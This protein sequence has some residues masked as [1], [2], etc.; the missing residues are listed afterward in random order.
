MARNSMRV[1]PGF[2]Q[3]FWSWLTAKPLVEELDNKKSLKP[4]HHILFSSS[5]IAI[6]TVLAGVGYLC[7]NFLLWLLGFA[8]A[9]GGIKQMQ[10][11]ICHNCAHD[12]VFESAW[13]NELAGT[14][15]SG[16]FILKPFEIY[17]KEHVLHHSSKALLTHRDDTLSFLQS[18]VGL[19][20]SDS[21]EAMWIKLVTRALSPVVIL[22]SAWGRLSSTA[23]APNKKVAA[24]TLAFWAATSLIAAV[25]GWI[26]VFMVAYVVPVFAGYHISSTFRLA[27]EHTWPSIDVLKR[28]GVDFICE[29]TTAVFVGEK[30]VLPS[31]AGFMMRGGCILFWLVKMLTFHLFV[32]IFIMV[33]DTPCHDFHH[34]RPR[35][36]DWPNYITAR[37]LDKRS[38][39]KPFPKN[40]IDCWGYIASVTTNFRNFQRARSY[41]ENS[42]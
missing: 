11:M 28:R 4:M 3:P 32:R 33:G 25:T 7:G 27:A 36:K 9:T 26:D 42:I 35:S 21:V 2:T 37:E 41:Y 19:K 1:L 23:T 39:C 13:K 29:S 6:G 24:L 31:G 18:V 30:L 20:P 17:K 14:M 38:G 15:I 5:L 10:V 34:R 22:R 8:L 16:L 40:Y 12:M